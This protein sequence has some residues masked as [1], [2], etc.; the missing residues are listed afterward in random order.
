MQLERSCLEGYSRGR[1][2]NQISATVPGLA[3]F[4]FDMVRAEDRA[5]GVTIWNTVNALGWIV[6]S[7]L[8][9]RL[10]RVAPSTI[11]LID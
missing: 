11:T 3:N 6:G 7:M 8:G 1:F 5:K 10:A 9:G 4:V 2:T